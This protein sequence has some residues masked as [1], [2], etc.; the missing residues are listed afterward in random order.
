M[1][2]WYHFFKDT[3]EKDP[4]ANNGT[5]AGTVHVLI[6]SFYC[7]IFLHG[8]KMRLKIMHLKMKTN[9][10]ASLLTLTSYQ[11]SCNRSSL[12]SSVWCVDRME[13]RQQEYL[14]TF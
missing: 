11:I 3:G 1:N 14:D 12:F 13:T 7:G 2:L 5:V 9:I 6:M 10:I 4:D 8:L